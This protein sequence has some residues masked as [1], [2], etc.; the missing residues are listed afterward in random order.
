MTGLRLCKGCLSDLDQ[1]EGRMPV[2][3]ETHGHRARAGDASRLIGA[4]G[5]HRPINAAGTPLPAVPVQRCP[6]CGLTRMSAAAPCWDCLRDPPP[7]S[8]VHVAMP[9]IS[10]YDN[11]IGRLKHRHQLWV[12]ACLAG[13]IDRTARLCSAQDISSNHT[14]AGHHSHVAHTDHHVKAHV[15]PH[16]VSDAPPT[17]TRPDLLVPIPA[18]R[19]SLQRRG[20]NPAG[21]IARALGRRMRVPVQQTLLQRTRDGPK[22]SELGRQARLMESVDLFAACRPLQ[23]KHVGLV[24]DVMTTGGT[25]TAAAHALSDRGCTQITVFVGARTSR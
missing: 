6:R 15:L 10:P 13:L 24:D 23:R 14:M 3:A 11:L 20:F 16:Q 17:R 7:F 18:S 19:A 4:A 1:I 9:Y 21:E 8:R 2:P 12:A 25:L 22:Q 5:T